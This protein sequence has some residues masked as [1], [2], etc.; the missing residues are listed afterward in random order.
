MSQNEAVESIADHYQCS[1]NNAG[2]NFNEEMMKKYRKC[3]IAG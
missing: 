2:R 3:F 1:N